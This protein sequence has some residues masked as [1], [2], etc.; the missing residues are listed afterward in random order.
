LQR[1]G[2]S[3][4][5][6]HRMIREHFAEMDIEAFMQWVESREAQGDRPSQG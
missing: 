1:V 3:Y 5:F 2:D 6:I 4:I